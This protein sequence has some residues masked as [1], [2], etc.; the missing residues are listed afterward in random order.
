MNLNVPVDKQSAV[1]QQNQLRSARTTL[2]IATLFTV[3]NV[4]LLLIGSN[5]YFLYSATIPY[6]LTF[7]GYSFDYF[8]VGTYTL[9]GLSLAAVPV[10]AMGLCW[11]M[12][13]K[14]SRWLKGAA[15]V[16]G[17]DAAALVALM[18]WTG[19]LSG[20]LLDIVFHA[21]VLISL[22]QGIKAADRLKVLEARADEMP[23][24]PESA[25]EPVDSE[26]SEEEPAPEPEETQVEVG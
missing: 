9:T 17:L 14:D 2:L 10:A 12:S 8:R 16:F 19:D 22:I 15:A 11:F 6:Y 7:F 23:Q 1:Y 20:S 25:E 4:V 3:L 26:F 24:T 18:L 5:R 13:K 21:W